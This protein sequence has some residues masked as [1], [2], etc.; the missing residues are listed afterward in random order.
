MEMPAVSENSIDVRFYPNL[1]LFTIKI[2]MPD[3]LEHKYMDHLN[4]II[5]GTDLHFI[6]R[7]LTSC[8]VEIDYL[9][10][11]KKQEEFHIDNENINELALQF[12]RS[13]L[14]L[15]FLCNSS[16]ASDES[17]VAEIK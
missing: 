5:D 8:G 13:F 2:R 10:K 9:L 7:R 12:E 6:S 16:V 3:H 1:K 17:R 15:G 4:S 11:A 14:E